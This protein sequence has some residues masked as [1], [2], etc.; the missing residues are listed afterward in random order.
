MRLT[1]T[2]RIF[3][4]YAVVLATFGAVSIF[5]VAEMHR[6]QVEIRL[7]SEGYLTLS[8]G[9]AG[10][11]TYHKNQERDTE[12][13]LDEKSVETRRAL[14]RLARLYFPGQMA[15]K[16]SE[17][18]AA[19]QHV[20]GFAP[21]S[22]VPFILEVEQRLEELAHRYAEYEQ[23]SD[24]V[25]TG[26]EAER[27]DFTAVTPKMDRLKQMESSI[28][29]S[30]RLLHHSLETRIQERVALAE[31]R[32]RR[33]G[34]AIIGLSLLAIGVGLLMT[35]MAARTLK[36]VRTLTEG[37]SRIARG[38]YSAQLGVQGE[39]EISLLAREFDAMARSLK[40]REAQLEAQ[41]KALLRAEQLA[42]V[43]R[44]AAQIAHEVRNPLS[45][46]GL[47][48]EMLEEQLARARF[49]TLEESR[50]AKDLLASVTREVDRLTEVTG[51]YLKL[52]R[53]QNPTLSPEDVNEL[54]TSVLDFSREELQ[55]SKVLVERS[56][57]PTAPRALADEGQLRQV[58]LNLLRNSREAMTGGGRLTVRSR[59]ANGQVEV[60]FEDSG[61]GMA[62]EVRSRI[63]EPFFTTKEGG[64]GLG[65]ALSR[66]IVQAHGGSIDCESA[67]GG[68]TTFVVRLKRA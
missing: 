59:A 45:S 34:V 38:D 2:T 49:G 12:R 54:V 1:L 14:I 39:D 53:P 67:P 19:A 62:P 13:L 56:L 8:Q 32:E 15:Q 22:E 42:A 16:I 63:F 50:E 21:D 37:V 25:F 68:G 43:G 29:V 46:I 41:Q 3:L 66:Q 24:A 30:I 26:L 11:E 55:R 48:V 20:L 10:I 17:G 57:D 61:H 18:R 58:F 44:I 35:A 31:Q 4:G 28:G 40:E 47:N 23:S 36:P 51:E 64:T 9:A 27:P 60:V 5:S 52:A 65:L 6:N 33:T 7:V